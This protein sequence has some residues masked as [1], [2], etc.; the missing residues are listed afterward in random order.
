MI[1]S[2]E[3]LSEKKD[4]FVRLLTFCDPPVPVVH[5]SPTER[6]RMRVEFRV[7]HEED[8]HYYVMFE[9]GNPPARYRVEDSPLVCETIHHLMPEVLAEVG[10]E[11][12]LHH[13]LFQVEFLANQTGDCLVTLIYHRPLDGTW[14]AAARPMAERL[15]VQLIGRSRKQQIVLERDWID[16][17][18]EVAGRRYEYRQIENSFTQP[19]AIINQ[20][21]LNWVRAQLAPVLD[22]GTD[23]LELYCGNGNFTIPLAGLFRK[24]LVTEISR[25]SIRALT[26]N[27]EVNGID[28]VYHAR[29]SAEE[30]SQALAGVRRFQ[31]LRHVP[32][33]ALEL[34]TMLVDPPR[35]GV[36]ATTL[37]LMGRME[38]LV[39]ISCN[40]VTLARDLEG[41]TKT[42]EL[43][44]LAVFDQ[45]PGTPH[46]EC[47]AFL[48][49]RGG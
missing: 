40:P 3:N 7:W 23:F 32:L 6:Y 34:T 46:L 45:F 43:K 36:D 42:H 15:G 29:M 31:R 44:A 13:R 39:Y 2:S 28:N 22:G 10:R 17:A 11:E 26:H 33:E 5:E 21:M 47:G 20:A 9:P 18:F 1:G 19:N 16:E 4:A 37:S 14:E 35:S 12:I 49:K 27:L 8:D 48:Q 38:R 24:V 41:L 25:T 30:L